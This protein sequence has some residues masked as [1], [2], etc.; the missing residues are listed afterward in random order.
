MIHFKDVSKIYPVN[1][2]NT[3]ALEKISFRIRPKEFVSLVGQSGAGKTTLF[4]LISGVVP[5]PAVGANQVYPHTS[6]GRT[7]FRLPL[8]AEILPVLQ[9]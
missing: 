4:G 2:E 5:P 6:P 1:S 9:P 3:I 8:T 7:E